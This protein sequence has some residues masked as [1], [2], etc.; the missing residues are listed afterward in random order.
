MT[1]RQ[2][3]KPLHVMS[4]IFWQYIYEIWKQL[5]VLDATRNA[6]KT[7]EETETFIVLLMSKFKVVTI[8]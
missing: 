2:A 6:H 4:C 5:F 1:R 7:N 3:M 8:L